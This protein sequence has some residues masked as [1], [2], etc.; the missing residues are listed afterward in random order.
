[1]QALAQLLD[2]QL[3]N[4]T[5]TFNARITT[6]LG[7]VGAL[8]DDEPSYNNNGIDNDD[9]S[10]NNGGPD[11]N[12][13]SPNNDPNGHYD[14]YD[15]GSDSYDD[16]YNNN[17][18]SDGHNGDSYD[19]DSGKYSDCSNGYSSWSFAVFAS[20]PSGGV[21]CGHLH[22]AKVLGIPITP[23]KTSR[24]NLPSHR[25]HNSTLVYH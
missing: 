20:I 23:P 7:T 14:G 21:N 9:R 10:Y 22:I 18:Y 12:D 15:N 24:F 25:L 13:D 2:A 8:T 16:G 17:E 3:N 11:D 5:T 19:Y 6:T 4:I 1:L